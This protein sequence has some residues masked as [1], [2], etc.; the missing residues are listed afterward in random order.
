MHQIHF[1]QPICI[2]FVI[3]FVFNTPMK[4]EALMPPISRLNVLTGEKLF[5]IQTD[6]NLQGVAYWDGHYYVGYDVGKGFG[7]IRKY[8][9]RGKLIQQ[10]PS[11]AIGHTAELDF[12]CKNN[13]LYVA[14][15]GGKH[16]TK[17]YEIDMKAE[18]PYISKTLD[19]SSLGQ[20]GLLAIDN[21]NDTLVI[22]TADHDKAAPKISIVDFNGKLLAQLPISYQGI[23]QGL[24]VHNGVIYFQTNNLITMLNFNG[25]VIGQ[26]VMNES[27]E[28]EGIAIFTEGE[29]THYLYAY[30]KNNRLYQT[31]LYNIHKVA[32]LKE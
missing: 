10:T 28:N 15:G 19:L 26:A 17:V 12:R 1:Y 13:R 32:K 27:G 11:L 14:N 9:S 22:H 6:D 23:P 31:E 20:A 30:R 16:S 21:E 5:D 3:I 2:A 7:K 29:K 18:K 4:T 8:N 25:Q 24:E